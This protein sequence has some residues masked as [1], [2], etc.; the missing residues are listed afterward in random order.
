ML[1]AAG[2]TSGSISRRSALPMPTLPLAV[3]GLPALQ[4]SIPLDLSPEDRKPHGPSGLFPSESYLPLSPAQ[5]QPGTLSPASRS[6]GGSFL[7]VPR[8]LSESAPQACSLSGSLLARNSESPIPG[9]STPPPPHIPFHAATDALS[10]ESPADLPL[11]PGTN[12]TSLTTTTSSSTAPAHAVASGSGCGPM[13]AASVQERQLLR[14]PGRLPVVVLAPMLADTCS[15]LPLPAPRRDGCVSGSVSVAH[16]V[17]SPV[18]Q[19]V[20]LRLGQGARKHLQAEQRRR[21]RITDR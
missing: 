21:A 8:G 13:T 18:I 16:P 19:P 12:P 10:S 14:V 6:E 5:G 4:L 15:A 17:P 7:S 20:P 1:G 9:P 2:L 11:D 3:T